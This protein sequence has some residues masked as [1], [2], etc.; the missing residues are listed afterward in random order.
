[1]MNTHNSCLRGFL[2][3]L[4]STNICDSPD[5]AVIRGRIISGTCGTII[6]SICKP[7]DSLLYPFLFID[8]SSIFRQSSGSGFVM[9]GIRFFCALS[10]LYSFTRINY[11]KINNYCTDIEY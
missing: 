11:F 1:M 6:D 5:K 4:I 9:I 10:T 7:V 8:G 2:R 3:G